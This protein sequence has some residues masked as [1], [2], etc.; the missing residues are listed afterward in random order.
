MALCVLIWI[1]KESDMRLILATLSL[2]TTSLFAQVQAG[3]VFSGDGLSSF[4]LSIGNYYRVPE[5]EVVVVHD[6]RIPPEEIPVVFFVAQRAHVAPAV[7]VDLRRRGTTWA[8]VAIHFGFQPDVYYFEGGPPYGRA[9]GYW[10]KHPP[11]DAEV[12]DAVNVHFFSEY[13][14]V[15]PN[16]VWNEHSRGKNYLVIARDYDARSHHGKG[17]KGGHEED[18]HDNGRGHGKGHNK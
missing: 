11:R 16:D 18:H 10:R 14:H 2:A 17:G 3:A 7:V 12:V 1:V 6:R 4:F 8:N 5:R 15:R 9:R 13:H